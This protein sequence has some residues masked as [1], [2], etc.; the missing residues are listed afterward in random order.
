MRLLRST[1]APA[2]D[3]N[4]VIEA[5]KSPLTGLIALVDAQ[6]NRAVVVGGSSAYGEASRSPMQ[7]TVTSRHVLTDGNA[8]TVPP[9][10]VNQLKPVTALKYHHAQCECAVRKKV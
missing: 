10:S 5:Y 6:G 8:G 1:H 4:D 2:A 3:V 7:V 9:S